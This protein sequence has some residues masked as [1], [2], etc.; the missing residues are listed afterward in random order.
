MQITC[1]NCGPRNEHEFVYGGEAH[2]E[3]PD[4]NCKDQDWEHYLFMRVNTKGEHAER[5]VHA[6]GCRLWFN[7]IRHT[8][9]H[10]VL[11]VYAMGESRP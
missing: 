8:V 10:E 6:H 9:S 7:I 2:V 11:H 4:L 3:R 5:W 1:P